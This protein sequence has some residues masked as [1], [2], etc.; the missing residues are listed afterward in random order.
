MI[1]LVIT[2][3]EEFRELESDAPII[4]IGRS[5][6]NV[7]PLKDRKVSR[8]HIR[9]E[10]VG[11]QYQVVDLESGNGTRINGQDLKGPRIIAKG[12]EIRLG[13]TTL[14]VIL[15]GTAAAPAPAP[16]AAPPPAA[17][18]PPPPP[19]PA[20][21][22][23]P[24][25]PV[26]AAPA[27]AAP[28]PPP[29]KPSPLLV[30]N[31]VTERT[32]APPPK[33]SVAERAL[34]SYRP[35]P[36]S[37]VK[38]ALVAA[39]VLIVLGGIAAGAFY[40]IQN[41]QRV[42]VGQQPGTEH[43]S[44]PSK[45]AGSASD[46]AEA[47]LRAFQS[48]ISAGPVNNALID[49]AASLSRQYA[50][51]FPKAKYP[52]GAPFGKIYEELLIYADVEKLAENP[53]R[54]RRYSAALEAL[55]P[56]RSITDAGVKGRVSALL[57]KIDAEVGKDFAEVEE[58]GKKLES[59]KLYGDARRHYQTHAA[60]FQGTEYHKRLANK[61]AI[62]EA[63][64]KAEAARPPAPA[65]E[66]PPAPTP[67]PPEP[68]KEAPAPAPPETPKES[69]KPPAPAPAPVAEAP[70]PAIPRDV[71]NA[72]AIRKSLKVAYCAK[73]DRVLEIGDLQAD[74][75]RQCQGKPGKAEVCARVYYQAECHPEKKS[76]K[77]VTCC[78][79]TFNVPLE[80]R[81]RVIAECQA[82]GGWAD[83]QGDVRHKEDCKNRLDV[84]RLCLK[85]G[86]APHVE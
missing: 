72:C 33:P 45:A 31:A 55:K 15:A 77:P 76:D 83:L 47:A 62:L 46:E 16:P 56:L 23:A 53:L 14:T 59:A 35:P 8:K 24:P 43:G 79:K 39:G 58:E 67:A 70:C 38:S 64:E 22:P 78:G 57:A 86:T 42:Q 18:P 36:K 63:L 65:P 40:V 75:C 17:P 37:P 73:C 66:T 26:A 81:A 3:P 11:D 74:R 5:L 44:G 71:R 82:C 48:R 32:S 80:D 28:P 2:N 27:P 12:D 7:I 52:S 85:S 4:T 1:K 29:P 20:A 9:I 10:K 30:S 51:A 13:V 25:V 41:N 68:P 61:P 19:P 69:S 50:D 84:R 60:R 34:T 6:D 49:E 21:A 54:E